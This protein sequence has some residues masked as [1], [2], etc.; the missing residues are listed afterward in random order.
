MLYKNLRDTLLPII[1]KPIDIGFLISGGLDSTVLL[2]TCCMIRQD[3]VG[4]A[5]FLSFT[6]TITAEELYASHILNY[7]GSQFKINIDHTIIEYNRNVNEENRIK[8]ALSD[9]KQMCDFLLMGD[10]A[11]P[12]EVPGGPTRHRSTHERY[13]QPFFDWT[14]KDVIALA[15]EINMPTDLML[16]TTTCDDEP[17]CGHCWPCRERIWGFAANNL[18][19][20][21]MVSVLG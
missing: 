11:N 16:V 9:A 8:D 3:I 13:V 15:T 2:Y 19:D 10:T 18:V 12:P 4:A 7:I 6:V 20:P 14:K 1:R 21:K 17:P 5:N